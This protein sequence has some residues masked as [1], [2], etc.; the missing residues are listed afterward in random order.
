MRVTVQT[1]IGRL[2]AAILLAVVIGSIVAVPRA[3]SALQ[4]Q[5]QPAQAA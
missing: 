3:V 4:L 2:A 5:A 1:F